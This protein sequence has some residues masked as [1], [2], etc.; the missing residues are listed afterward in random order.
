MQCRNAAWECE[1]AENSRI[2][3]KATEF[4]FLKI[5]FTFY[6]EASRF[7]LRKSI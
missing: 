3:N 2:F 6:A 7:M 5:L 1:R 4:A